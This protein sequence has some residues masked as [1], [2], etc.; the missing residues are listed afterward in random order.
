[1]NRILLTILIILC[2]FSVLGAQSNLRIGGL[3][4]MSYIY[5][6]AEDSLNSY[7]S[8]AFGFNLNY[9]NFG[10]GM[11]YIADLP[12]YS[13][14]QSELLSDFSATD[15]KS[16]WQE[17]YA[18][19]Q[20]DAFKVHAG[21]IT[22]SFGVGL[23]FRSW[24][25]LEFDQ[26]NRIDGFLLRYDE[27]L[28][29][30][31]LYGA[32]PNRNQDSKL[33]LAYGFDAE[34]PML[35]FL[36]LGASLLGYRDFNMVNPLTQRDIYKERNLWASRIAL[37]F[38]KLEIN[39]EYAQS[40]SGDFGSD[41]KIKGEALY[42]NA[43]LDLYPITLGAAYKKYDSFNHR[44]QDL[45]AANYHTETLADNLGS[46]IDEEGY[47]AYANWQ[48]SPTMG[49]NV[50]YAEAWNADKDKKMNDLYASLSNE[51]GSYLW[52][53]EYAHI[54]KLDEGTK[55]W[56]KEAI[57][58]ATLGFRFLG[59]GVILKLE[60]KMK[61]KQH[62]DISSERIEPKLQLDFGIKKLSLSM[63]AQTSVIETSELSD[64]NYKAN[65]EAKYPLWDHS[66]ITI[67][68]GKDAGG[69]V[70]RN[71]TCRYVAPFQGV[72]V[73]LSTRF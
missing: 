47:Q 17:I 52:G 30:K 35:S 42:G 16:G 37:A 44:L 8:N 61:E 11:K 3:N 51:A 63:S 59:E 66:D 23:S 49:L 9:Q 48:I 57:P 54:E 5:R 70:C 60:Y 26:D 28:K 31:A 34:Y 43:N 13:T 24:E 38:E 12:K 64:A 33:D 65:V 18:Y 50:D 6:T 73:E 32:I 15:L 22:E 25:D 2:A 58:A 14:N 67:F 41:D 1:M 36:N 55:E 39:A 68:A 4:E 45:P 72:K 46:G 40:E 7:F 56:Q 69:K 53:L 62:Y 20:K 19:Y 27:E 21:T 10:F 29:L 71:G